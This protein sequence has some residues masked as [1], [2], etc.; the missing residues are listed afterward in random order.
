MFVKP[1]FLFPPSSLNLARAG[2][3][4]RN[5]QGATPF[6]DHAETDA[7]VVSHGLRRLSLDSSNQIP[8]ENEGICPIFS[9]PWDVPIAYLPHP[10]LASHFA[11]D[12]RS[13]SDNG[14]FIRP[15]EKFE[16]L[17]IIHLRDSI[18]MSGKAGK[19]ILSQ[20]AEKTGTG[21]LEI[22]KTV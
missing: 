2:V 7:K 14:R 22:A 10:H 11:R 12:P 4:R 3:N 16:T 19:S 1:L 9:W 6:L 20:F 8:A 5:L 15:R 13:V 21:A 17:L 18:G